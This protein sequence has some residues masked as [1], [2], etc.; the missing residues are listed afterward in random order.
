MSGVNQLD[1]NKCNGILSNVLTN[2][3]KTSEIQR[4]V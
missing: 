2:R 4:I 1:S 3:W